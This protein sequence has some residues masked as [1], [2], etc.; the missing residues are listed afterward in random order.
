MRP[1]R[2]GAAPRNGTRYDPGR[3]PHE[4]G[5]DRLGENIVAEA[6]IADIDIG[7]FFE[8]LDA[9]RP[10]RG[11]SWQAAADEIWNQSAALNARRHDHPISPATLRGMARRG[12]TACQRALFVL[13]WLDRSS[14]S[15]LPGAM[16]PSRAF[17]S[18]GPDR[19]LRWDLGR[20]YAALGGRR[21]E[22]RLTWP[23][24]ARVLRCTPSQ[25][26][27]IR[28]AR[29]AI[30]MTLAIRIVGWHGR[31]AADFIDAAEW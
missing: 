30:G 7:A 26:T 18:A 28:T 10:A 9:Q 4:A 22:D 23:E 31:P 12:D 27:G 15:F 16:N 21:H 14:E 19:L 6:H 17:P 2:P 3:S 24:L 11:L 25:L 13:R 1:V 29:F 20:L 8:A 5:R